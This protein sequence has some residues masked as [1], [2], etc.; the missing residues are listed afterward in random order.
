VYEVTDSRGVS[1]SV[2]A[3]EAGVVYPS[4]PEEVRIC[5]ALGLPLTIDPKPEPAAPAEEES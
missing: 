3:D 1:A 4:S 5:D 2:Q